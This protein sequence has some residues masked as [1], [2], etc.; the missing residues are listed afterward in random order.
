MNEKWLEQQTLAKSG[1]G[2]EWFEAF[3]WLTI[4]ADDADAETEGEGLDSFLRDNLI[5]CNLTD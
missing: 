2:F 3:G 5:G 4:P 1:S